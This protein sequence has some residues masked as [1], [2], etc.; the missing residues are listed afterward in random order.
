VGRNFLI[1]KSTEAHIVFDDVEV[2]YSE[3]VYG[4]R[5]VSLKIKPGEFVFF[6]GQTG[7]G[8]STILK[9]L[10]KE[11]RPTAGTVWLWGVDLESI[12]DAEIPLLR[13]S[14]GIVPQDYGLLPRKN[15]F[16]NV[17]YAMR[18]IGA[19]KRE[20]RQRVPEILDMVN[21]GHRVDA[22]P[23]QLSGGERQRVAIGRALIN[24]PS[25]LV[26]DEP[27]GNLDPENSWGIME[28]LLE[29][30]RRG[31]TILVASHD[32]LIVERMDK[33]VITM[34]GGRVASDE[35]PTALPLESPVV[36]DMTDSEVIENPH[37]DV[38][39]GLSEPLD[40]VSTQQEV[41]PEPE[42]EFPHE[43]EAT[44]A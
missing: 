19:T 5:D 28:L 26:A 33:R 18:A 25:L 41:S 1:E 15:V 20:V 36:L 24:K 7:T 37:V 29:L 17:A 16:E 30:N 22:F 6:V 8:K 32:V 3:Y 38:E 4:L 31:T 42:A 21:L 11:I 13:R 9:L 12:P 39:D 34:Q 14:M 40:S 44:N 35:T 10:S 23:D 43:E 27:T 2:K